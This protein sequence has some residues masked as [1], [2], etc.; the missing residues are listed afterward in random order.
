MFG[1]EGPIA[2]KA[3]CDSANG[4][5]HPN[6]FGWMLHANVYEGTDLASIFGRDPAR[7]ASNSPG[8]ELPKVASALRKAHTYV[9]FYSGSTDRL[10]AQN[11]AFAAALTRAGV[12]HRYFV[13]HGGHDW[14]L[15]RG[16]AAVAVLAASKHLAHA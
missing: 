12:P 3:E 2:S 14:S 1:P 6:V 9:W 11:A 7:L 8:E 16:N 4:D 15:W 5:F 13:V 10:R